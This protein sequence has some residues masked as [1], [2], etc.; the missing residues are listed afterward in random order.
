M[1]TFSHDNQGL[2]VSLI[3]LIVFLVICNLAKLFASKSEFQ[4]TKPGAS[5]GIDYFPA[6]CGQTTATYCPGQHPKI[7]CDMVKSCTGTVTLP[8]E[9]SEYV[10]SYVYLIAL[11]NGIKKTVPGPKWW[12]PTPTNGF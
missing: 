2:T 6:K 4:N 7:P 12:E 3:I 8:P 1:I 11:M 5:N 9:V 10:D